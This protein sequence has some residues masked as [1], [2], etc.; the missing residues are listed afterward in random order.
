MRPDEPLLVVLARHWVLHVLQVIVRRQINV[1]TCRDIVIDELSSIFNHTKSLVRIILLASLNINEVLLDVLGLISQLFFFFLF[2]VIGFF[3]S[4][5][6]WLRFPH[7][8]FLERTDLAIELVNIVT[9]C[10]GLVNG[11][12]SIFVLVRRLIRTSFVVS[13]SHIAFAFV[14][15]SATSFWCAS[16]P[17]LR[18]L[19]DLLALTSFVRNSWLGQCWRSLS[20]IDITLA[21]KSFHLWY[22]SNMP[23]I[24][25]AFQASTCK[26]FI[27][28]SIV[29]DNRRYF[30]NIWPIICSL[31]H[32]FIVR[33]GLIAVCK[34]NF[35]IG[36]VASHYELD[37]AHK[38][39]RWSQI[40]LLSHEFVLHN[41]KLK[42]Q[43][44][45][46]F[47]ILLQHCVKHAWEN[48]LL[49]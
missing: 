45:H 41:F 5:Y 43:L 11:S 18:F 8:Q 29:R 34:K 12:D 31:L 6:P 48:I 39:L 13:K 24:T 9:I 32:S 38:F 35:E 22:F 46:F 30:K 25:P 47:V 23:F 27:F 28:L 37:L 16:K 42:V 2:F 14:I 10:K 40:M 21:V 26:S 49:N 7:A 4:H 3:I 17:T 19:C 20:F 15:S 1:V 33:G 44:G 36:V